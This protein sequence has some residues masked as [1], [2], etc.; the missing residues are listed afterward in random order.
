MIFCKIIVQLLLFATHAITDFFNEVLLK[1]KLSK[2][3]TYKTKIIKNLC[4]LYRRHA[5]RTAESSIAQPKP[6]INR[7]LLFRSTLNYK[8]ST[9][10]FPFNA[11]F[12]RQL[13][14]IE[15]YKIFIRYLLKIAFSKK[16]ALEAL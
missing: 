6:A 4:M 7:P 10:Y 15:Q 9:A 1:F 13:I 8:A 2:T 5:V 16:Q 14:E 12:R 11:V 3:K